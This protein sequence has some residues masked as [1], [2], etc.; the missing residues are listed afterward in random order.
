MVIIIGTNRWAL[1][2]VEYLHT[3]LSAL[4]ICGLAVGVIGLFFAIYFRDRTGR[5]VA[6]ALLMVSSALVWPVC[7][8]I[9]RHDVEMVWNQEANRWF[10]EEIRPREEFAALF[11]IVAAL[12]A[13]AI[14][15]EWKRPRAAAVPLAVATLFPAIVAV[16]VGSYMVFTD[17]PIIPRNSQTLSVAPTGQTDHQREPQY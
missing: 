9:G 4:P 6:L 12:S 2:A 1:G 14:V 13:V 8:Y 17:C 10:Q 15:T 7:Y 11:F 16:V 3:F 5:L